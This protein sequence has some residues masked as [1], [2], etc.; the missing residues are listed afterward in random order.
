MKWTDELI[1]EALNKIIENADNIL[2]S[3]R[4]WSDEE[5]FVKQIKIEAIN[6]HKLIK[7]QQIKDNRYY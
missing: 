7:D 2:W 6:I 5:Y 3:W 1:K 4:A